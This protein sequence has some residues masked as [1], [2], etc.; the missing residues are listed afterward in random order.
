[1]DLHKASLLSKKTLV[2][3]NGAERIRQLC[4]AYKNHYLA[5]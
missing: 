4:A 2:I 5:W 1:M 3:F